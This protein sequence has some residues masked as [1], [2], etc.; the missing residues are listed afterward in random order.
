VLRAQLLQLKLDDLI[1][2]IDLLD[3]I[4][5]TIQRIAEL[6]LDP[7]Q[8]HL[9]FKRALLKNLRVFSALDTKTNTIMSPRMDID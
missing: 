1:I 8:N 7:L 2:Y 4:P 5:F 6:L 3:Q 9:K